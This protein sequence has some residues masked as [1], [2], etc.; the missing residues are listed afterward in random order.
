MGVLAGDSS[1]ARHTS[2]VEPFFVLVEMLGDG[3]H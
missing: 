2:I 1:K 3:G